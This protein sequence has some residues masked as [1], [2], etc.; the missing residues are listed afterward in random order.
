MVP[1]KKLD[2]CGC[3]RAQWNSL[4]PLY[5]FIDHIRDPN[6]LGISAEI[7]CGQSKPNTFIRGAVGW[8]L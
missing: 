8:L 7:G 1:P 5:P 2:G 6:D 3:L 4:G